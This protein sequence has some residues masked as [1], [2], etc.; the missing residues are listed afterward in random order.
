[1]FVQ[2][3]PCQHTAITH[4]GQQKVEAFYIAQILP[5]EQPDQCTMLATEWGS[6]Q[7][8]ADGTAF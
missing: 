8:A 6:M 7:P 2:H 1:M 5:S 4:I 3:A